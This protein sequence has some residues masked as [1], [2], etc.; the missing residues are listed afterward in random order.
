MGA[1][2][3]VFQPKLPNSVLESLKSVAES[4]VFGDKADCVVLASNLATEILEYACKSDADT[5]VIASREPGLVYYL[6]GSG[7]A[8]SSAMRSVCFWWCDRPDRRTIYSEN[9]LYASSAFAL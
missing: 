1:N 4:T 8:R 6:I 3:W 9:S 5:M 7:A 2:I